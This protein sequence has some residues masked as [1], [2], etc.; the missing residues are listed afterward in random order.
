MWNSIVLDRV[1]GNDEYVTVL[2][3][4]LAKDSVAVAHIEKMISRKKSSFGDDLRLVGDYEMVERDGEWR[5]RAEARAPAIK[6][7][8]C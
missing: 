1:N 7:S 8:V 5:L 3:K 4:C 2:R 6:G